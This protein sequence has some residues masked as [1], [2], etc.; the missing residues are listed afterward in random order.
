MRRSFESHISWTDRVIRYSL[1]NRVVV[2][3][4]LIPVVCWGVLV[5]PFDWNMGGPLRTPIPVDA[6]PDIGENQQIV[7][8]EWPG[9]SPQDVEDQVTYP[10]TVSLLGISGVK[11]IRS[12]SMF[13]FST[14]YVIFKDEVD[15]YWSRSRIL[16]RLNSLPQ[17]TLPEGV[18][19]TLGPDA[20]GMGQVFWYLL[21][22]QDRQGN[23]TG[24]WD[25]HELRTIQDWY[26]RF[27]L[28]SAEGVSEV[29]SVGGFVREYQVELDPDL[30]RAQ[31]VTLNDVIAAVKEANRDVG[32]RSMEV[33][34]VEYVIRGIGFVKAVSDIQDAMI[35]LNEG[36][37]VFVRNVATVTLGPAS[38]SGALDRG[39][40]EVVGGVVVVRYGENPLEVIKNVRKKIE[41]ITVGLPRKTMPDGRV[42]QVRIVPFY[43]RTGL[44]HETLQTLSSALTDEILVTILVLVFMASHWG[45]SLLISSVLPLAIMICFIFMKIF[46]VAANV[47]ALSGIA[48]AIGTLV[49]MGIII[50]ENILQH[51]RDADTEEDRLQTIFRACREVGGAVL[52]AVSATIVS[53]LPV[54]TMEGAEGKLFRPLAYTKTF[55]LFAALIVAMVVIP[56]LAR[57]V[58]A[59][60]V[61]HDRRTWIVH[62]GM[63][64]L[65][66]AV[67]IAFKWWV[68]LG[69]ALV[70][71]HNLLASRFKG[72]GVWWVRLTGRWLALCGIAILLASHWL[73]VGVEKGMI[74]NFVFVGVLLGGILAFFKQFQANY[75]RILLWCLSHKRAFLSLP[76]A[77]L[78]L[79]L[80]IWVGFESLVSWLPKG[81]AE[82]GPV[83]FASR[84]FPGLREE[85]M[86][87]LDEGSYLFMPSTLPH[88]SIG[89]TLDVLQKQD[90]A[91]QAIPEVKTVV[92]KLGRAQSALDPA[93]A[94]MIETVVNYRPKYLVGPGGR[95]LRFRFKADELDLFRGEDGT[96]V[97]APDGR[98]YLVKGRFVRDEGNRLIPDGRGQP[99]RVWRP[100][101]D[102]GLNPGRKPW[103]GVDRPDDIWDVI[104]QAARIPGTTTPSRLQ[105]IS[106]RMVMLQS[107]IRSS[108][109]IRVVGPDLESVGKASLQIEGCLR[110]IPSI[111]PSTV[112]AE[113]VLGKPYI[114]IHVDRQAIAQYGIRLQ[115]VQDV[116][117]YAIGGAAIAS[118]VEG[119]ERYPVRVRYAREL[120][121]DLESLGRI[122]VPSADGAQIPLAQLSQIRYVRG[123]EVIRGE[124]TFLAAYVLF[125]KRQGF[126]EVEVVEQAR[127]HL[128]E[129]L[130]TVG[131]L[132][133]GVSFDFVGTYENQVRA[134]KRLSLI[135]PLALLIIFV[136]LYLQ[137]KSLSTTSLVFSGIP[138]AWAGGFILIWL[139]AQPWFLDFHVFGAS[140]RELFQV[141]PLN[142]SVAVWV[143]FLALFGVAT[144]DGVVMATYLEQNM[145]SLRPQTISAIRQA[146]MSGALRRVR[147][148]L[149][150]VATTIIA[151]IPVMTSG[152]RGSEIMVPMA[153]PSFGGLTIEVISMLIVPVLYCA[154]KERQLTGRKVEGEAA[155]SVEGP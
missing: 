75:P 129:R 128:K 20:T 95:R 94:S 8:T 74:S 39:G 135:M 102:P 27:A 116:I 82:R 45:G 81:I 88:A 43:D 150:T 32:A 3:L 57:T 146:V 41:A 84:L 87:P 97:P 113:R 60:K 55:A 37:P 136:I 22:G 25:L 31:G 44:I 50:V 76:A 142:L 23:P 26:V 98:P 122:L 52:T 69:L 16:E 108:M 65:G 96:P 19:P 58:F 137:F 148:C 111:D 11:A 47:V 61:G 77:I 30:M 139:Y 51:L 10:L 49:D 99:F 71:L 144:D 78:I 105:P 59:R 154:V 24:G 155:L 70:G 35:K 56:P 151:L 126:S 67:G 86:P 109:G 149:M 130:E 21:E 91:I 138:V 83:A 62:E 123:P 147:P 40:T 89:E 133:E 152:G 101:L 117:E 92:G 73:P 66:I 153:I 6:I 118:T 15:F 54:L 80:T 14:V 29:A 4:L 115:Q 85:F 119:R 9:R 5:S 120:R 38:R 2:L 100:P 145:A 107:G 63:I 48:I 125:D 46:G 131:P 110:E 72:R 13:G 112:I 124:N 141:H 34:R 36:V 64:Y 7:F 143:G 42:S 114:E 28:L 132:P 93:P 1:E 103:R 104:V 90:A 121:D 53:F 12:L 33:N 127:D 68:W 17:G 106:A 134:K 18:Q 140:L 79:G